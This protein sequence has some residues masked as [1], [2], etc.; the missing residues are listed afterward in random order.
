[1]QRREFIKL[2]GGAA[3]TLPLA[4]RAQQPERMRRIG[5]LTGIAGDDAQT[6]NRTTAFLQELQKFGWAEGRNLRVDRRAGGGSAPTIRRYAAE[7]VAL[8]PDA[9]LVTGTIAATL[10]LE[11]TRTVPIVFTVVV[12]PVG[13]GLIEK[14]SRPNGNVTGFMMFDYSLA[15]KWAELLKQV[16]PNVTEVAVLRDPS[17]SVGIGQF[18]IIQA[19]APPLGMEVSA[20]FSL[21]GVAIAPCTDG[22]K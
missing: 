17:I 19:V 6:E 18:A 22:T 4:A 12:D 7:L 5:M 11:V 3:A 13:A 2:F 15:G 9:I 21:P 20:R 14:L 8:A 16:A 10:L 1:M